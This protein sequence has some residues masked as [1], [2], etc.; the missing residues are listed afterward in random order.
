M[1]YDHEKTQ[2]QLQKIFEEH[3]NIDFKN[4]EWTG[5]HIVRDLKASIETLEQLEKRIEKEFGIA[6]EEVEFDILDL[7][8]GSVIT[9]FSKAI[10]EFNTKKMGEQA[11]A[12]LAHKDGNVSKH[13]YLVGVYRQ[14]EVAERFARIENKKRNEAY[15]C[16]V[17]LIEIG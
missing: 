7:Y 2:K 15:T 6:A 1:L 17:I 5:M 4:K 14:L 3:F 9:S 8:L 16:S 11:Y 13:T 12:V 10:E